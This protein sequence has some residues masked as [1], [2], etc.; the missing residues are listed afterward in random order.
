[1]TIYGTTI[2]V[3]RGDTR[4][5]DYGSN[6]QWSREG[7]KNLGRE[8]PSSNHV[9]SYTLPFMKNGNFYNGIL[10]KLG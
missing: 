3:I 2:G 6:V 10:V 7:R 1:M 4:S 8:N 5:L 9:A